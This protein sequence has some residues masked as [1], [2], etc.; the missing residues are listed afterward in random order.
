MLH[1]ALAATALGQCSDPVLIIHET[2]ETRPSALLCEGQT[3]TYLLNNLGLK[4]HALTGCYNR[5]QLA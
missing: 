4:A 1:G 2:S 5:R 3:N